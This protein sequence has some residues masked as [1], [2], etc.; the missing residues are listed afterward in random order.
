[1][2]VRKVLVTGSEGISDCQEGISDRSE[3]ISDW[4]RKVLVTG[5]GRY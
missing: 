2:T 5:S 3:G 4:V 1:M